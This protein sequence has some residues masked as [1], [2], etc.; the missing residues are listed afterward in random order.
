MSSPAIPAVQEQENT[1]AA[2]SDSS[3]DKSA[4]SSVDDL[5]AARRVL[6]A[7]ATALRALAD[8]LGAPFIAALDILAATK[9]RVIISGMG[10]S[11]H[12]GNKIAA[13][14]AS[15]GTPAFF[16]HPGEASHGDL[17]MIMPTDTVFALSNSGETTELADLVAYAA[18]F[19]IPLIGVTA[20]ADSALARAADVALQLP[21]SPEA[22]PM[23]LAPT[24]STTMMLA[25]GDAI[26]VALLERRGFSSADFKILH[27][28]GKLGQRL[29]KVSDLMHAVEELPLAERSSVMSDVIVL[30]TTKRFGCAGIVDA[31]GA[32][33]GVITDGD[34]RRNMGDRLLAE[35]A[36]DVMTGGARTIGPDALASEALA[37]MNSLSI[38]NLFVVEDGVP[39]GIVHIHDCLRAGVA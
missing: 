29:L 28:G 31:D 5:A 9:G 33:I 10:K 36:G 35:S 20:F 21:D 13:T 30:M 19:E 3:A 22:C 25:L 6:D 4:G 27:P 26:A 14:L 12:I 38:T 24:T 17:G 18:R 7:G 15:T 1:S 23:G 11:G 34:L 16:V 8:G 37:I 39:V 32:L 2:Q